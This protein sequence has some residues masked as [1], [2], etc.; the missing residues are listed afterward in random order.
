MTAISACH[1][2]SQTLALRFLCALSA[3][4]TSTEIDM[5][6]IKMAVCVTEEGSQGRHFQTRDET[7][8]TFHLVLV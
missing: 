5:K 3:Y 2:M 8:D 7:F 1:G 4:V 6:I